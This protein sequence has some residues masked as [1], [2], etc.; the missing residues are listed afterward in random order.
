MLGYDY[1]CLDHPLLLFKIIQTVLFTYSAEFIRHQ[2][3][4]IT[5]CAYQA[6]A[7]VPT[8]CLCS[9]G[10]AGLGDVDAVHDAGQAE[11]GL[12]AA[13]LAAGTPAGE[14]GAAATLPCRQSQ[15][16]G[17]A[18]ASLVLQ[19]PTANLLFT[20]LYCSLS[21]VPGLLLTAYLTLTTLSMF[22]PI[23]GRAGS[24][25]NPDIII[26]CQVQFPYVVSP[27]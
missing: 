14:A 19:H 25:L 12:P 11:V 5:F 3:C 27:R 1:F 24:A 7:V 6:V 2:S 13:G 22:I 20:I 9:G 23:M 21:L 15:G 16:L 17:L 4:R 26:G 18:G 8:R 10:E